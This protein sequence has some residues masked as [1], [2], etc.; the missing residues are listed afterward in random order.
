METTLHRQLKE[1][2]GASSGGRS[3]V[4]LG[5]FRIDAVDP[6]GWLIEVQSGPLSPLRAKLARLLP[7]HRVRVVKPVIVARR[8]V[9]RTRANSADVSARYSPKRGTALD[10]FDDLVGLARV[11]PHPN[12][13]IDV[14]SIE[15]DEVRTPRRRWPG[16]KVADRLLRDVLG[17]VTLAQAR[18]LWSLLPGTPAS[19]FTTRELAEALERSRDFA[20]RVAYCLRLSGAAQ[21]VGKRGNSLVYVRADSPHLVGEATVQRRTVRRK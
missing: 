4:T 14:L 15:I 12:L 19:P 7:E 21:L 11:F 13:R 10:V 16:F 3:E 8:L 9:R 18:D 1:R 17:S 6:D 5:G 20:Q 2:F